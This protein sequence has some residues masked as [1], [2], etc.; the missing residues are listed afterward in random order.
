MTKLLIFL[1]ILLMVIATYIYISLREE[2]EWRD[3]Y[4]DQQKGGD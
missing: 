3:E 2:Q 1:T 4:D